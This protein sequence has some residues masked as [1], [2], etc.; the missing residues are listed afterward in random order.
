MPQTLNDTWKADLG[1]RYQEIH[2]NYLNNIGN[3]TLI[4]HNSE[5]GNRPFAE[6]KEIYINHA[7][8]QIAK[9]RIIEN[10]KWG[11]IQIRNRA[12]YLID[13]ITDRVLPVTENLRF[14]NNY[15]T[16][17]K[18]INSNNRLSFERLQLIDKDIYLI[19]SVNVTA[20]VIGD[21]DLLFEGQKY[22]L[23]PLTRLCMERLGKFT[24]SGSYWGVDKWAYQNKSLLELMQEV[25]DEDVLSNE[26]DDE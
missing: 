7:G 20:R 13:H 11:E 5:L 1:S 18:A 21:K 3:L 12:E 15:S 8:M 24:R 19:E 4:K 26:Q 16:E 9:N 22:K 25:L 17:K 14:T 2:D 23:S 10:E 6:K